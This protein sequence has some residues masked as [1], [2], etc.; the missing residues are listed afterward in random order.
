[1]NDKSNLETGFSLLEIMI[2]LALI[3]LL[4]VLAK[5]KFVNHRTKSDNQRYICINNLRLIESAKSEWALYQR[6]HGTDTPQGTDL[7]P[8]LVRPANTKLPYCPVD[9]EQ[10]FATSYVPRSMGAKPV[11]LISPTTHLLP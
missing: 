2:V 3:V 8:Y 4:A 11:C 9:P 5:P 6:K 7:Q 1:M 10:T